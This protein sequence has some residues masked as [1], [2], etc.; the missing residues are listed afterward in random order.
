MAAWVVVLAESSLHVAHPGAKDRDGEAVQDLRLRRHPRRIAYPTRDV[1][2]AEGEP[3]IL[4]DP[5]DVGKTTVGG[6]V[7]AGASGY[8]TRCWACGCPKFGTDRD[9]R[10]R[11]PP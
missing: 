7:T 8:W 3:L 10:L 9:L 1:P 2:W 4:T 6:Q 11:H 5:T